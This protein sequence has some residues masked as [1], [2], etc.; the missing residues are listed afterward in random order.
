MWNFW[1]RI[2]PVSVVL[3][4]SSWKS[5]MCKALGMNLKLLLIDC[6]EPTAEWEPALPEHQTGMYEHVHLKLDEQ[7][8]EVDDSIMSEMSDI[9]DLSSIL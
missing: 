5:G 7:S 9:S 3:C 2:V 6:F 8:L 1:F 4:Q